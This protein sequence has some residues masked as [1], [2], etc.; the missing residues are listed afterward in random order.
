MPPSAAAAGK[1]RPSLGFKGYRHS[2]GKAQ[3]TT[4]QSK[5]AAWQEEGEP[6]AAACRAASALVGA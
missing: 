1:K 3:S 4:K 6:T 5:S 2:V